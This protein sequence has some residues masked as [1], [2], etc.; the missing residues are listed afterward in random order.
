MPPENWHVG[1]LVIQPNRP[2]WGPG[3][4]VKVVD[5]R[6][7]VVWRDL[8]DREAKAMRG[9]SLTRSP[10]QQDDLLDNLPPLVEKEGK[11]LLPK[12]RVTFKQAVEKF[13]GYFPR[14]FQDPRFLGNETFKGE[15]FYKWE[16]HKYFDQNLKGERFRQLLKT[17]LAALIKEVERC[18]G[19][20][21][22]LHMTESA[23]LRDGLR[24]SGA[25]YVMLDALANLLEVSEI[26]ESVYQAYIDSVSRLPAP[27][28]KVAKWTIV[29]IIPFLAQP[30][31]HMFLKPEV[32]NN[33]ADSLGFD[34]NYRPEPNWLTYRC[35]LRMST[36]YRDKLAKYGPRDFIDVQSFFYAACGGYDAIVAGKK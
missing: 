20:V 31:R 29:T 8:P 11:L 26:S 21:N 6:V 1:T 9:S 13:F 7:Y 5:Q 33:A 27:R 4:I 22:V 24:D 32:T 23:A 16:A 3:K 28:G 12:E 30:D 10:N 15:R 18:L 19:K 35:L 17:D 34:L 2:E 25:A 36:I 14:G